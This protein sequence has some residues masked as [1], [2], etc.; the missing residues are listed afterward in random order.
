MLPPRSLL[1]FVFVALSFG[2][3]ALVIAEFFKYHTHER[4]LCWIAFFRLGMHL[5]DKTFSPYLFI[6]A[7]IFKDAKLPTLPPPPFACC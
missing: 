7:V 2:F 5:V 6:V 3:D 4:V 1:F